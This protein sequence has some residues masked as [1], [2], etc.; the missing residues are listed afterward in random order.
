[1]PDFRERSSQVYTQRCDATLLASE[2]NYRS[3]GEHIAP[4]PTLPLTLRLSEGLG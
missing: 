3:S 4:A 1:M 2:R